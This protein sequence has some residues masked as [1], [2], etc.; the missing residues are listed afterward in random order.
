MGKFQASQNLIHRVRA[1]EKRKLCLCVA[2][3]L[4][5]SWPAGE[6]GDQHTTSRPYSFLGSL[7]SSTHVGDFTFLLCFE[8]LTHLRM[9]LGVPYLHFTK[10]KQLLRVSVLIKAPGEDKNG[11]RLRVHKP[12]RK[13][14]VPV[15]TTAGR[16]PTLGFSGKTLFGLEP[17]WTCETI[18]ETRCGFYKETTWTK[19]LNKC[20][21]VRTGQCIGPAGRASRTGRS[22]R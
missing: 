21:G 13:T 17:G 18:Q 14:W 3:P 15:V 9:R 12:H 4:S 22:C 2:R 10:E 19:H 20:F 8:P 6:Q 5:R 16:G 7:I 11:G 1:V